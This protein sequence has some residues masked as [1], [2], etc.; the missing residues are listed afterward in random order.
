[1]THVA[2]DKGIPPFLIVYVADHPDNSAQAQRLAA[3]LKDAD[4]PVKLFGG[5]ETNHNRL[6]NNLGTS[7]DSAT[8]ALFEFVDGALK[9]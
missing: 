1:V 7:D 5:Q 4:V 9:G 8:K 2:K 3:A 6:N